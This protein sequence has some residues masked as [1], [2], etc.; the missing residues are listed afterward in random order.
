MTAVII[1]LLW[2]CVIC[3]LHGSSPHLFLETLSVKISIATTLICLSFIM[4]ISDVWLCFVTWPVPCCSLQFTVMPG[5]CSCLFSAWWTAS[6]SHNNHNFATAASPAQPPSLF[7]IPT[8]LRTQIWSV[9]ATLWNHDLRAIL[10]PRLFS[11]LKSR[12]SGH[13][14][15]EPLGHLKSEPPSHLKFELSGYLKS[16]PLGHMTFMTFFGSSW[17]QWLESF[18]IHNLWLFAVIS[19]IALISSSPNFECNLRC[20][21]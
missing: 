11:L 17:T 7:T 2:G 16:E 13:L 9:T 10:E 14:K 3:Y 1:C 6:A 18:W 5:F 21:S 19:F 12:P 8:Q 20:H 15:S 4:M